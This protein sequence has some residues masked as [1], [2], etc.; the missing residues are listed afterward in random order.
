MESI[1]FINNYELYI[2]EIRSVVKSELFP[3]IEE[4]KEIYSHDLVRPDSYFLGTQDARGFV[5]SLFIKKALYNS[6]LKE[7]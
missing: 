4:L 5:W 1:S 3:I 7:F 2:E 6:D